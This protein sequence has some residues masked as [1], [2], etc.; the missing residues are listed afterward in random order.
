MIV[1][2]GPLVH[3]VVPNL[4]V[5]STTPRAPEVPFDFSMAFPEYLSSPM[6]VA[7]SPFTSP[8][9]PQVAPQ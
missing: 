3:P 1:S 2:S 4:P 8:E 7:A 5:V 6:S 9:T